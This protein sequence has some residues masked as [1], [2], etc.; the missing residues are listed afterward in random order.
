M[1]SAANRRQVLG[2]LA[3]A[4]AASAAGRAR[5]A[6][7]PSIVFILA[8][9]LGYADLSC[10]GRRDYRTPNIDRLATE[11]LLLTQA[12]ANSAMCSATRTALMTGRYQ[13]RLP[14]G[15]HEPITNEPHPEVGLPSGFPTLPAQLQKAGYQTSLVGKWHL[16]E[17][18]AHGPL[19]SGYQRFFGIPGGASD[20]FTHLAEPKGPANVLDGLWEGDVRADRPGYLTDL[21][22]DRAA[23]EVEAYSR[24]DQPYFLSLHFTAP[25]WPWEGPTDQPVSGALTRLQD[26]EGGSLATYAAMM[27]SLDDN[28]DKVLAAI[29]RS[30]QAHNTLVV[31][32]SDNGG[33]R[34][35]DVWPLVGGKAELL[36]G[37]IRVP[38][39][40]R[41]PAAI[42]HGT[43]CDQVT[44]TMDWLPT[45]LAAAGARPDTAAPPDGEDVLPVLRG[46]APAHSRK[47][48]WRFRA[49]E[50]AAVREGDWKYLKLASKE[51]LFDLAVDVRERADL[52]AA[53]PELFQRLKAEFA[54]W[55]AGMLPYAPDTMG[56]SAKA[57]FSDRY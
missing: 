6:A 18:P 24:L 10:Y 46:A 53:R 52:K 19:R 29:D 47:L 51:A 12:Y 27:R 7:A 5:A 34:F 4:A 32:T 36:E 43:R 17:V 14:V 39:L 15:L 23:A 8:D 56:G 55:N 13:Y 25:H 40:V 54:A 3:A 49:S 28:V 37:G 9:D 20:Y 21:L 2:G 35:S 57:I 16:G 50:Q 30:G 45:L 41:W 11:G 26:L 42:A 44:I 22:G 1:T 33:E 38:A 48:F 31:F